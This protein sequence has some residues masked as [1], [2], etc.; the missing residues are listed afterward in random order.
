MPTAGQDR[1]V[2]GGKMQIATSRQRVHPEPYGTN[3]EAKQLEQRVMRDFPSGDELADAE[4]QVDQLNS[5]AAAIASGL[6]NLRRAQAAQGYGLRGDIVAA[7][8]LMHTNL[9]RGQAAVDQKDPDKAKPY[10]DA[11]EAQAE[12][13]ER[14][15][16][17]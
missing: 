16:G 5:R 7:E 1:A 8:D 2:K 14:F 17:R 3:R 15:L 9:T 4:Q 6:D 13:I 10:L 11:A 12:K